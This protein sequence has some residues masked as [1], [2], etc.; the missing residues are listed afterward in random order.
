VPPRAAAIRAFPPTAANGPIKYNINTGDPAY[1][2]YDHEQKAVTVMFRRE[3]ND[4]LA[5]RS[6]F[7]FQNNDLSYRQLYVGGFATTGTGMNVNTEYATIIRGGGGADENFDTLTLDSGLNAKFNTGAIGHDVLVGLDYLRVT[8]ENV[9]QFNTGQTSNPLTSIPNLNLYAPIYGGQMPSMDLTQL[10]AAY[11]NTGTT[12]DQVGLYVQDQITLGGLHLLAAGRWDWYT[13]GTLNKKNNTF[14]PLAQNAFTM[15]LG[16]LYE[17]E[18]GLSPYF[19]YS[20]SFEP[21][22]GSDYLGT[23]FV[24]TTGKMYEGGLKFQPRGMNALFTLAV[25]ELKRQNVPV[26][27]PL[28][29]T[30][31]RPS[32]SQVQIGETRVRGVEIEGRGEISPGLDLVFAGTYTDA[33]ITQGTPSVPAAAPTV[34]RLGTAGTPST[35]GTVPL[36]VP[37]WQASAFLSYDFGRGG[38]GEKPLGGL[39]IGAGFRYVSGS[40][41]STSYKVVN[42]VTTFEAFKTKGFTL[43]DAMIG[44]DL[45][46]ASPSLRGLSLAVN[47]QNLF[48]KEHIASCFF[49]NSCYFGASRT[50]VGSL[51]YKW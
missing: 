35:T 50:L 15:R 12:R 28:A 5:L 49:T 29:G 41:G 31:G 44:Y 16:A 38:A 33:L 20:E 42:S 18:F 11:I 47:A 1:E 30:N 13:Q 21:Q 48:N 37:E 32:N 22:A 4:N 8:G 7:R 27:D 19:S 46:F 10:S 25:Y 34:T 24:P 14:T 17:F 39:S 2:V 6:N 40:Y 26:G 23:P 3:L 45:G 51:R 9:Q 36:G 43:F